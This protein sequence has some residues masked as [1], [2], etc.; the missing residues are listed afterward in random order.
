MGSDP[1]VDEYREHSVVFD[2]DS[3]HY[4]VA[5]AHLEKDGPKTWSRIYAQQLKDKYD[6][7][8]PL[9]GDTIPVENTIDANYAGHSQPE[10]EYSVTGDAIVL[11]YLSTYYDKVDYLAQVNARLVRS[12]AVSERLYVRIAPKES[13]IIDLDLAVS[14]DGQSLVV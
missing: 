3:K 7:S 11:T 5:F 2:V 10:M 4:L 6:S 9:A 13:L 1:A 14:N 12:G 8:S